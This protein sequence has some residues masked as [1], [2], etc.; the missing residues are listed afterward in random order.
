MS[1][2]EWLGLIGPWGVIMSGLKMLLMVV[3]V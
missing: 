3:E 1:F 2:K